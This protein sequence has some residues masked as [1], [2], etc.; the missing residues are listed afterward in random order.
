VQRAALAKNVTFVLQKLFQIS[1]E[2]GLGPLFRAL[3]LQRAAAH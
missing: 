3:P 1:L 2:R